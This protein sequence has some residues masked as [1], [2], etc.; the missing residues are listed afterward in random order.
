MPPAGK[1]GVL[2]VDDER[3]AR[4]RI[5]E[6]LRGEADMEI[7][8]ECGS[9]RE[10]LSVIAQRAPDLVF[11]DIQMP[12]MNG[13]EVLAALGEGPLPCV[14]FVTAYDQFALRAFDV[15]ALD[16]LLKPFDRERFE[17]ALCRAREALRGRDQVALNE[18]M[19]ALLREVGQEAG[20]RSPYLHRLVVKNDGRSVLIKVE[21][22]D[23]I[24]SSG[25]YLRVHVAGACHM[26][27]ETMA[28]LEDRLDPEKFA[29]IH[30]S[31]IVNID[32]IRE[33]SPYFHGDYMVKLGDGTELTLSRSYRDRLQEKLGREL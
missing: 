7:V 22:V 25:N 16:Y 30:R 6:L 14:V 17:K 18:R 23:W 4:D 11:L 8:G 12:E 31:A 2:L 5:R 20:R 15:H 19:V 29:R 33:L 26:L 13:F 10:A 32:R 9:G 27:R 1:I 3:L 28:S 24:E 21:D